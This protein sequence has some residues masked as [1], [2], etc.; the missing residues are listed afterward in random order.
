MTPFVVIIASHLENIK[1]YNELCCAVRSLSQQTVKP[2]KVFLSY[3][4]PYINEQNLRDILGGIET[5]ILHNIVKT[6]QFRHYYYIE[7]YIKDDDIVMFL[8]DDDLYHPLKVEK[9]KD[10]FTANQSSEVLKHDFNIFTKM[11]GGEV[12]YEESYSTVEH[13]SLAVRG[14][15]FKK[16]FTEDCIPTPDFSLFDDNTPYQNIPES[17]GSFE[18]VLEW[19]EDLTDLTFTNVMMSDGCC[20]GGNRGDKTTEIKDVLYHHQRG[21]LDKDWSTDL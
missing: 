17:W 7:K 16:F 10:H 2:D 4:G 20:T 6:R 5:V 15:L 19:D 14:Y 21:E 9:T 3:S 11:D 8:D 13:W 12:V 18:R 1:R